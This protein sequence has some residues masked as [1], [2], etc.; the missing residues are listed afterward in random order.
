M[1]HTAGVID[2]A[3]LETLSGEQLER[4]LRPKLDAAIHLQELTAG[5]ELSQFVLF[6][7]DGAGICIA[8]PKP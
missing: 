5:L 3:T 2:D 4:V 1:V 7:F 8:L 6:S